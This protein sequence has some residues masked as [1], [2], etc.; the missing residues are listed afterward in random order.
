MFISTLDLRFLLLKE[1]IIIFK[2]QHKKH[3]LNKFRHFL[4][5]FRFFGWLSLRFCPLNDAKEQRRMLKGSFN[6]ISMTLCK[7]CFWLFLNPFTYWQAQDKFFFFMIVFLTTFFYYKQKRIRDTIF[8]T[9]YASIWNSK[10]TGGWEEKKRDF[11]KVPCFNLT[12]FI[13]QE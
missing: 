5:F 3:E 7:G 9:F 12:F 11:R 2:K 1:A 4:L 6:I 13:R 8:F 10:S